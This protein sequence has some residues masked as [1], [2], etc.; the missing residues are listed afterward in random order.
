MEPLTHSICS[1]VPPYL[2]SRLAEL[3]PSQFPHASAAAA[4][5][6]EHI[7]ALQQLRVHGVQTAPSPARPGLNRTI[8]DAGNREVLPGEAVR[9]EGEQATGDAAVDE[10]Y[11][12][13]GQTYALFHK[14]FG[15]SSI[16]DSGGPL[17]ATVHYG[18]DYDNAFWNGS[19][20]VF[21]DGDGEVFTRFTRSVTVIGHELA[22]GFILAQT[23]LQYQGQSGALQESMADVFGVLVEQHLLNQDVEGA[24]WLVGAGLFTDQVQGLA[25]RSLKAPGT[26][27]D[28]DVLG[29]D[30]QPASMDAYVETTQDRGGVHINSGIPNRAFYLCAMELGGY[31]W[32]R[33]GRIW[34][35]AIVSGQI[36]ATYTFPEFATLTLAAA[37]ARYGVG[38]AEVT[39]TANAWRE[40]G[41]QS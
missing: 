23:P 31:A 28:D 32:E 21:G 39:A 20:M 22:H 1:I 27:Y 25:L 11:D 10:A 19:R 37:E 26:A 18:Q 41:V 14:A 33:A 38:S 40:T 7:D 13:L 5:T 35:D 15:R 2:L 9:R 16:D 30:P 36:A 17:D 34:Y 4:R 24:S 29:K 12:G 3:P 6:L 8:S